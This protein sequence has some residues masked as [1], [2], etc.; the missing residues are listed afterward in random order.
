MEDKIKEAKQAAKGMQSGNMKRIVQLV[1]QHYGIHM[2]F[3]FIGIIVSAIA[4][5]RGTAFMQTL[6]DKYITPMIGRSSPDFGPLAKAMTQIVIVYLIGAGCS[7]MYQRIMVN[8]GQ[9]TMRRVRENLFSHMEKLPIKY[10]DTHSHGDIMSVYTNDTDTLR[11]FIGQA[12]PQ[13]INSAMMIASI[14]RKSVV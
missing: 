13:I 8:V 2:V 10:F 1:F 9:G 5:V 3:V 7:Y 12:F 11:Q 14:D 4:N 6:I